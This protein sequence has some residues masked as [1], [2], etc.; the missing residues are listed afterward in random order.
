MITTLAHDGHPLAGGTDADVF[1]VPG[2][3]PHAVK[4]D[5]LQLGAYRVNKGHFLLG[6]FQG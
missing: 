1:A 3:L 4:E 6:D 2:G 5:G